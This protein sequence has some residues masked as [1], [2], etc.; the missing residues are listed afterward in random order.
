V[1]PTPEEI[2]EAVRRLQAELDANAPEIAR[3]IGTA[4]APAPA[5]ELRPSHRYGGRVAFERWMYLVSG[6]NT[7]DGAVRGRVGR[8]RGLLDFFEGGHRVATAIE[9][10]NTGPAG[11]V[12]SIMRERGAGGR[13]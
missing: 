4:P 10:E 2:R 7:D 11:L 9:T 6:R 5:P 1:A 12:V 13:Y 8:S 3:I